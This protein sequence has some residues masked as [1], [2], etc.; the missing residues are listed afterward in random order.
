[1]NQKIEIENIDIAKQLRTQKELRILI[2]ESIEKVKINQK[3]ID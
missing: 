1:L 3:N 2:N